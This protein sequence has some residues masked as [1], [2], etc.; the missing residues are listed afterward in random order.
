MPQVRGIYIKLFSFNNKAW[1]T[2]I[3]QFIV[4]A[5]VSEFAETARLGCNA[6]CSFDKKCLS[7]VDIEEM[8]KLKDCFWGKP[9]EKPFLPKRRKEKIQ[10]IFTLCRANKVCSIFFYVI[11]KLLT[12]N[13]LQCAMS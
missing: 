7:Y 4:D 8:Y 10:D 5:S 9:N 11:D 3:L 2:L 12:T 1:R 13:Y 6:E